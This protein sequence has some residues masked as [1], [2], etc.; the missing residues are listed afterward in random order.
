MVGLFR[1]NQLLAKMAK[2]SN[3]SGL[4]HLE[5]IL[6]FVMVQ[7]T[8]P[9]PS[10]VFSM[11]RVSLWS[12]C[13]VDEHLNLRSYTGY[14]VRYCFVYDFILL[15]LVGLLPGSGQLYH[16]ST[17]SYFSGNLASG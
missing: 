14:D 16:R 11:S 5:H 17:I 7:L 10:T 2:F 6:F 15:I 9:L 3:L 13:L 4:W 1:S 12:A 8:V